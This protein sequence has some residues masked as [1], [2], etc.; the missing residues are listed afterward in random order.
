[1]VGGRENDAVCS[2]TVGHLSTIAEFL[3]Y[4]VITIVNGNGRGTWIHVETQILERN[5]R[6][7]SIQRS[8]PPKKPHIRRGQTGTSLRA[9]TDHGMHCREILFT[10]RCSSKDR[11]FLRLINFYTTYDFGATGREIWMK[12]KLL[13]ILNIFVWFLKKSLNCTIASA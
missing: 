11:E 3:L 1:M 4:S 6:K 9:A 13:K 2:R 5:L 7:L 10:P 8:F 12:I